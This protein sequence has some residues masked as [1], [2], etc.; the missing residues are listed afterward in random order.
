MFSRRVWFPSL[1][2]N[3]LSNCGEKSENQ[4]ERGSKRD[5]MA[6]S[7]GDH[8]ANEGNVSFPISLKLL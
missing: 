4:S 8:R 3:W 2:S 5:S 1:V 6:Q 7:V